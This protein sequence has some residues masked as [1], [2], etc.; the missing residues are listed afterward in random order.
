MTGSEA[1]EKRMAPLRALVVDCGTGETKILLYYMVDKSVVVEEVAKFGSA[2]AFLDTPALFSTKVD[3]I[4]KEK[5]SDVV[6]V[7]ATAWLRNASGENLRKGNILLQT[8]M[9]S[10]V[11][12]KLLE[13]HEEGWFELL[14]VEFARIALNL[15]IHSTWASGAGSTQISIGFEQL[16]HVPLGNGRG[17]EIISAHGKEGIDLWKSE[18]RDVLSSNG[19]FIELSGN[20][21]CMSAVYFASQTANLPEQQLLPYD[22][23]EAAFEAFVDAE[24]LKAE[25]SDGDIRALSNVIQHLETMKKICKKDS[26]FFFARD[27][28]FPSGNFR[29]TWS[30]GWYLYILNETR[31]FH[32]A[33]K[34]L[35]NFRKHSLHLKEEAKEII[36]TYPQKQSSTATGEVLLDL[37]RVADSLYSR[38]GE[39]ESQVTPVLERI[40]EATGS[41]LRSL[42]NKFKSRES[43]IRK[44]KSRLKRILVREQFQPFF[45]PRVADVFFEVDDI[46]RYTLVTAAENYPIVIRSV[47]VALAKAFG[48]TI[49]CYNYWVNGSTYMGV[50][51]FVTAGTFTFELQFH[52]PESFATKSESH[53]LYEEFRTLPYGERKLSLY[54]RMKEIWLPLIKPAELDKFA[55]PV[56]LTDRLMEQMQIIEGI[57]N[58]LSTQSTVTADIDFGGLCCRLMRGRGDEEFEWLGFP[59]SS[60]RV[61][62]VS[63]AS[64]LSLNSLL[65]DKTQAIKNVANFMGKPLDWVVK[66]QREGDRFK[67]A[68]MPQV[69]CTRADWIGLTEILKMAYP[70]IAGTIARMSDLLVNTPFDIVEKGLAPLTFR[71]IKDEGEGHPKYMTLQRLQSDPS[72][73]LWQLRGFL[74]NIVGVNELYR[75]DGFVYNEEGLRQGEEFL[76][77]NLQV[78][79]IVG[80]SL[81]SL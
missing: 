66:K 54:H 48:C 3:S 4:K 6:L 19:T 8:L 80:C 32:F 81:F 13:K 15:D 78:S 12:C 18:I 52:T 39:L 74:Y 36:D 71:S 26:K 28:N 45:I 58:I 38:A 33:G 34:S 10:G 17:S 49:K 55:E 31:A 67:M 57:K 76:C 24:S 37:K 51:S 62:W 65:F 73:S 79:E 11:I 23:V 41:A 1:L 30:C 68:L 40:G 47:Q 43:L 35:D 20:I 77:E 46:L 2:S 25:L 21:L 60:K 9:E 14:A 59:P 56:E 7:A 72:P 70:E 42:E 16:A 69:N 61:T 50:N 64:N 63:I 44:L 53:A 29:V 75:G 22:F 27:F 5:R